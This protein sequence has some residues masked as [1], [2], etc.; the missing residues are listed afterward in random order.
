M[1]FNFSLRN[2]GKNLNP[3]VLLHGWGGSL[4]SLETLASNLSEKIPNPI[5]NLELAGF[6]TTPLSKNPMCTLDYGLFVK[7]FLEKENL[8]LPILV[9][10]SFG[11]KTIIQSMIKNLFAIKKVILVNSSGIHPRNTTKKIISKTVADITP[12]FIKKNRT[13]KSLL[14][15]YILRE[16][17]YLYAGELEDTFKI[18]V[19]EYFDEQIHNA[20][21][22]YDLKTLLIWSEKDVYTPLWMAKKLHRLIVNS[23]LQIVAKATHGLPLKEPKKVAD[24]ISNWLYN[25]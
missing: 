11:G 16:R 17:D 24:T 22:K 1:Q 3:I 20:F 9:G 14:Y 25:D 21:A 12:N 7:D 19:E 15:K 10:H 5:Y 4:E 8:K 6:G 2:K 13:I 23:K 18:V